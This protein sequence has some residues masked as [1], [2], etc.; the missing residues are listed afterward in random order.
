VSEWLCGENSGTQ[1]DR[2]RCR[3]ANLVGTRTQRA[4]GSLLRMLIIDRWLLKRKWMGIE[5]DSW[6]PTAVESRYPKSCRALQQILISP[7]RVLHGHESAGTAVA[8]CLRT[9]NKTCVSRDVSGFCSGK[10]RGGGGIPVDDER[11]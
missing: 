10:E 3:V 4:P 6:Q 9:P 7:R 11:R 5:S 2:D 1:F 8:A